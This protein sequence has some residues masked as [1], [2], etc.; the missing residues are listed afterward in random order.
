LSKK[1]PRINAQLAV[2]IEITIGNDKVVYDIDTAKR[3]HSELSLV[4][5]SLE[6][7]N[8]LQTEQT[9]QSPTQGEI[10]LQVDDATPLVAA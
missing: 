4:L 3:L 6:H 9:S 5:N 8:R 1:S 2:H 7:Q 10:A